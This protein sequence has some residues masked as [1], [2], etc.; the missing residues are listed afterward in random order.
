[1][2]ALTLLN[3][4]HWLY[5]LFRPA[6]GKV[7][8]MVELSAMQIH[9]D[10]ELPGTEHEM[11]DDANSEWEDILNDT[12]EQTAKN[13][14]LPSS[15]ISSFCHNRVF[16]TNSSATSSTTTSSYS[17]PPVS[18]E[19]EQMRQKS[20]GRLVTCQNFFELFGLS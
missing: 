2:A 14:S 7:V 8:K 10:P 13:P 19:T 12:L 20:D 11:D 5:L 18:D 4:F 17:N 6:T 3:F 15:L 16:Q 1:M 9:P